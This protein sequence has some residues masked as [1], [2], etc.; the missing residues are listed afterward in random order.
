M[1]S[2]PAMV[3]VAATGKV[4][5]AATEKAGVEESSDEAVE[6]PTR[7]VEAPPRLPVAMAATPKPPK[8]V[9]Q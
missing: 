8:V 9:P 7:S 5:A 6:A 4:E 3:Q 2:T 1:P